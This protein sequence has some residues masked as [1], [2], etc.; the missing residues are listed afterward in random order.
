MY[1]KLVELFKRFDIERISLNFKFLDVELVINNYDK[2]AAWLMYVELI[3][4]VTTQ[5]LEDDSGIEEAAL[6]SVYNMFEI[7][8]NV[9]KEKGRKAKTFTKIAIIILNQKIRPFTSKWHKEFEEDEYLNKE[10]CS[11]FRKELKELQKVL[12]N[13]CRLLA[14]MAEVEELTNIKDD[15]YQYN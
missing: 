11:E 1:M 4:R 10:K 2:E 6:K 3:T 15:E 14:D 13:Y 5:L 8:R 7:T 12:T 9:L